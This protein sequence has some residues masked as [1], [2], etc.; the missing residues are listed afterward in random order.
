MHDPYL[1]LTVVIWGPFMEQQKTLSTYLPV[2]VLAG[3]A[4]NFAGARLALYFELPL[5]LDSL[6]TLLSAMLGGFLPGIVV[7]FSSNVINGIRDPITLYYGLISIM[8]AVAAVYMSRRGFFASVG[9]TILA[10][11]VFV[12]IGGG[13]GS[14]LTWLLYGLNIGSGI[15]APWAVLL[16]EQ[17]G[18]PKFLA[19][20]SADMII[21]LLDKT[22]T[23]LAALGLIRL[24]PPQQL[25]RLPQGKLFAN[26][27]H[28]MGHGRRNFNR[29]S[30]RT[31]ML[32]LII[33]ASLVLG[34]LATY[35]SFAVYRDTMNERFADVCHSA[36]QLMRLSVDGDKVEQWL[37]T[38][39]ETDGDYQAAEARLLEIKQ[40]FDDIEYMYVYQ[41]REDGC[42]VVFDLDTPEL[43]GES[44][45]TVIDFDPGFAAYY[46][47]LLAGREIP[48]VVSNDTYGWLLTVYQ[49]LYDSAGHCAAYC[50]A[51]VAMD[52]VLIDR[53][54][55]IIKMATLLFGA[56]IIIVA[57]AI[58][59]AEQRL[60]EPINSMT[61][62]ARA[63]A[64]ASENERRSSVA[65]MG[66]LNIS[67]GNEIEGLYQALYKS[68]DDISHYINT[69]DQ[70]QTNTLLSFASLVE[71]RDRSTGQHIRRTAGVV[72][73]VAR[74]L[75][76]DGCY[77]EQLSD[78]YIASLVQ[79]APLHDVGKIKISDMLLNK[80]GKLT[81][82]E[83]AVMQTHTTAGAEI[84]DSLMENIEGLDYLGEAKNMAAYHH[85]RWDGKGYPSGL[86][87]E[88]IPLSARIMAVADVFDALIS[89]RSYKEPFP[90]EAARQIIQVEA[91]AHFD[92]KVVQAFLNAFDEVC[93]VCRPAEE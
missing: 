9:K 18:L 45:G 23:V 76:K 31:E 90:S 46:P 43:A 93:R 61:E 41:I 12:L 20:L 83:F 56:A 44:L 8:L 39:D 47:D 1:A 60:L 84:M 89:R 10:I 40:S 91:G 53:Y 24:T 59:F 80:P 33:G 71:S 48:P 65:R 81:E 70:L 11:L 26:G 92:P 42:H 73:V 64:Y 85:E 25:A 79:C 38:A 17:W 63:F 77:T 86:S 29:H 62:S 69:I 15:S 82:E 67:T 7:G 55:F 78:E 14:V 34:V 22:V 6:G 75:R 49:P 52:D 50:A 58:W 32:T 74:Q 36:T 3:I 35:I 16:Y 30:L 4:I 57:I 68:V 88:D 37:S 19:Q 2:L 21:D 72:G 87:G 28:I 5:F 13:L 66:S 54:T 27:R 51:D